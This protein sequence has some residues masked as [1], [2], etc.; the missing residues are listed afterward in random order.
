MIDIHCPHCHK[1]LFKA[2]AANIE[3]VCK[4]GRKV[5]INFVTAKGLMQASLIKY[6]QDVKI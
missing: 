4:C 5:I 2:T 1:L 3:I 6:I